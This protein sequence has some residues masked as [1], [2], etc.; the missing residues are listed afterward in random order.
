MKHAAL[1]AILLA[2]ALFA[3]GAWSDERA[4]KA[5]LETRVAELER[6]L[7]DTERS[8]A[9]L[10][11]ELGALRATDREI[12]A[13]LQR[14]AQAANTMQ[15]VLDASEAKGFTA[16]INPNSRIELLAGLRSLYSAAAADIPKA[17]VPRAD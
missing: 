4:Q 9:A 12:L 6:R 13:Y 15:D 14:Q 3:G 17:A 16:G 1:P 7:A 5:D 2:C 11:S 10:S 8:G